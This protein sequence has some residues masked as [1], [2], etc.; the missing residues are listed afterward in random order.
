MIEIEVQNETKWPWKRGCYLAQH[1]PDG[2][3]PI[4]VKDIPIDFEVKGL[5]TFKLGVPV[6]IPENLP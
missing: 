6:E 4:K 5:Q 2:T 1:D 3:C